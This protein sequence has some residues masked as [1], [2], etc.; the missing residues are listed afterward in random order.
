MRQR[1]NTRVFAE[2]CMVRTEVSGE[3]QPLLRL[4]EPASFGRK[5]QWKHCV[6]HWWEMCVVT[7]ENVQLLLSRQHYFC[8]C[9][10]TIKSFRCL[11][12]QC[13]LKISCL[14]SPPPKTPTWSL[15][16]HYTAGRSPRSSGVVGQDRNAASPLSSM[17]GSGQ[18][19]TGWALT[20]SGGWSVPPQSG[21]LPLTAN[22]C[23]RKDGGR[24]GKRLVRLDG[25]QR[26]SFL[27]LSDNLVQLVSGYKNVSKPDVRPTT[28]KSGK[29][30][31]SQD[32]VKPE[33]L[34]TIYFTA[35]ASIYAKILSICNHVCL[36][37]HCPHHPPCPP[38]YCCVH[39]PW[40]HYHWSLGWL[41][42]LEDRLCPQLY[43]EKKNNMIRLYEQL[44]SSIDGRV[45][46]FRQESWLKPL[47]C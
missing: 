40:P 44:S 16:L 8:M 42:F 5:S 6:H 37:A 30:S 25:E 12:L 29:L 11:P 28:P 19:R 24:S 20:R 1:G 26:I 35:Q 34:L 33:S 27:Y 46:T 22:W 31:H 21:K 45:E 17:E 32:D 18:S 3:A 41:G 2:C 4:W 13:P 14:L 43:K 7:M 9:T 38:L 36:S 10:R 15:I 47:R 39:L 23:L